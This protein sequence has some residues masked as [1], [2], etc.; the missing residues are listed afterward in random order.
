MSMG[1]GGG[2]APKKPTFKPVDIDKT[3]ALAKDYD[4]SA[5]ERSD[6]DFAARHP[7]LVSA[8]NKTIGDATN[9]L[10]GDIGDMTRSALLTSGLRPEASSMNGGNEFKTSRNAGMPI[11]AKEKRD[12]T[13]FERLLGEN[14][15]RST[16]SGADAVRIALGNTGNVNA[17]NSALYTSRVDQY[18]HD[19]AQAGQN[20]L[21]MANL[22]SGAAANFAKYY[23]QPQPGS[24]YIDPYN[25]V[26][27]TPP[28]GYY[29]RTG[30]GARG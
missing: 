26:Y 23:N 21:A 10:G 27:S 12:R 20:T 6:A 4:V 3:A 29:V 8:R 13:Y 1:G 7:E 11:L 5:Y 28:Y 19:Q 25:S 9:Q 22:F 15:M 14:P 18:T 2:S 24:V 16:F 30:T 17:L